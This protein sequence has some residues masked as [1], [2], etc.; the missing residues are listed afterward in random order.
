MLSALGLFA[1]G[2]ALCGSARNMSWLIAARSELHLFGIILAV[3]SFPQRSKVLE[4]PTS[5]EHPHRRFGAT[6]RARH[7]QL[8]FRPVSL[9]SAMYS[10][11]AD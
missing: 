9:Q 6:T 4:S 10:F 2:S 11:D 5:V 7:I 3:N 1:L 8:P